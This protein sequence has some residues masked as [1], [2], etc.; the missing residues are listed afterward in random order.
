MQTPCADNG[1][2]H[3]SSRTNQ[4]AEIHDANAECSYLEYLEIQSYS[5]AVCRRDREENR[6]RQARSGNFIYGDLF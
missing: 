4:L 6:V 5:G 2:K 1:C 3:T